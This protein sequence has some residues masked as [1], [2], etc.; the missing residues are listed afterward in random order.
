[1]LQ[2]RVGALVRRVGVVPRVAG[3]RRRRRDL[4]RDDGRDVAQHGRHAPHRV[5]TRQPQGRQLRDPL[6]RVVADARPDEPDDRREEGVQVHG[7]AHVQLDVAVAVGPLQQPQELLGRAPGREAREPD[8]PVVDRVAHGLGLDAHAGARAVLGV[9]L[10]RQQ[11][12]REHLEGRRARE[13]VP[14]RARAR[15]RR[16]PQGLRL[17]LRVLLGH[18][19]AQLLLLRLPA[20]PLVVV[21]EP[22]PRARRLGRRAAAVAVVLVVRVLGHGARLLLLLLGVRVDG[23]VV[24]VCALVD[25]GCSPFPGLWREGRRRR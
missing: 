16:E 7:E 4:R 1:M 12:R 11:V 9:V 13:D 19:R 8:G 25:R 22:P 15:R 23:A 21:G 5:P 18:G 3:R 2:R 17:L 14:R 20:P 6:Q 24:H 10:Q